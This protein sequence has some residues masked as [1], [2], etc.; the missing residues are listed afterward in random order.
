M[1]LKQ[2]ENTETQTVCIFQESANIALTKPGPEEHGKIH[3]EEYFAAEA[4]ERRSREAQDW[5][6]A[7]A[8]VWGKETGAQEEGH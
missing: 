2:L 6:K 4:G 3:E 1:F 8:Q 5:G 7:W